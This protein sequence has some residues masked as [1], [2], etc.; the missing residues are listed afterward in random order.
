M[1]RAVVATADANLDLTFLLLWGGVELAVG[2][3]LTSTSTITNFP[4]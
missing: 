2:K 4:D 3:S 1:A